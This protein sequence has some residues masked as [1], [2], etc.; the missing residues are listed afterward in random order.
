MPAIR[1]NL[2]V[3]IFIAVLLFSFAFKMSQP[4]FSQSQEYYNFADQRMFLGIPNFFDVLTNLAFLFA[5]LSGLIFSLRN[6][7]LSSRKSWSVCFAGITLV[8]FGSAYFHWKPCDQTLVWDRLPMTIGF[9]GMSVALISE[10]ISEKLESYLLIPAIFL[11]IISV[12]IWVYFDDLRFYHWIQLVPQ[13]SIPMLLVLFPGRFTHRYL[14]AFT[15]LFYLSAKL[16]EKHDQEIFSLI[17][18]SGH[19]VKHIFAG[20]ACYLICLM[21][22]NRSLKPVQSS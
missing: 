20:I 14:L 9:M 10:E 22:R 4:A 8:C 21:L 3:I 13:M 6:E 16:T 15:L 12:V 1:N 19:S 11:G 2:R 18:I 5:G 17:S 7:S